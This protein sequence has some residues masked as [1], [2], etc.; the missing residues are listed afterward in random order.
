[1][2]RVWITDAQAGY[3]MGWVVKEEGE[4]STVAVESGQAVRRRS[5][6]AAFSLLSLSSRCDEYAI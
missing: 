6:T 4:L 5:F 1:M 2:H 3:V